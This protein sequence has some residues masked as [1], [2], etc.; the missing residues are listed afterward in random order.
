MGRKGKARSPLKDPPLRV[1]GQSLDAEIQRIVGDAA[2]FWILLP[3]MLWGLAGYEWWS[4][5]KGAERQPF[6]IA[7]A[8]MAMTLVGSYKIY[9]TRTR[10]R[11]L[12]LGLAGER[13]VGQMLE[14]LRLDGARI[15]HDVQGNAFNVDHVVI[16]SRGVYCIE[17]KT[18]SKPHSDAK[19]RYDGQRVLVAGRVLDRDPIRQVTAS[20]RW[21][22]D[23]IAESTGKRFLVRP[24]VVFP[25]WWIDTTPEAGQSAVWVLEPKALPKWIGHAP[26]T[27]TDSDVSL[28]AYHLGQVIRA[29]VREELRL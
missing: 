22:E 25:R 23:Q 15:F 28:I 5:I 20:A 1:P 10:V 18:L 11:A 3:L 9:R 2:V 8:A 4:M 19:I 27:I 12:K 21:L 26:D 29:G 17:T 7:V 16:S 14:E 6:W 13:F 24:V